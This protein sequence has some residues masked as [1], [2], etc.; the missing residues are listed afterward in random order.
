MM[1]S[2]PN[3]T[4]VGIGF[5]NGDST[6]REPAIIVSVERKLPLG[7]MRANDVIPPTVNGVR[8][9][10]VV[11]GPFKAFAQIER[12]RPAR[13]GISIG[14]VQI[15][16]G[17]FGCVVSRAGTRL[18]L[19][20]N[21]VLADGNAAPLGSVVVQPGSIDGG[22]PTVDRIGVLAEFAAIVFDN[23]PTP[24]PTPTPQPS[25]C[26][27]LAVRFFGAASEPV[28][29]YNARGA[30]KVDAAL[31]K[32]DSD[33]LISPDIL[34]IGIPKGVVLG[35]LGMAIQKSGR[36]TNYTKGDI[37]QI[38]VTSR[39]DYGGKTATFTGQFMAGA[40]SQ[41]GD[42]GS[43]VLDMN[44]NL[45]GLLFAGSDT[46]TLINPIQDVLEALRVEVVVQI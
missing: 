46:S 11:S 25:G 37:Q 43:A 16:A 17:T 28:K 10:V 2:K 32:P 19:S 38:D 9:D 1:F 18:I 33:S 40:I 24:T 22:K 30:N 41:P 8:T 34:N 27:A 5:K 26:G 15:T 6:S 29:P 36:T 39:V 4:A 12:L 44:G 14:N 42:S 7:E 20:N 3:V 13:P 31:C 23:D 21:H 35:M 45:M